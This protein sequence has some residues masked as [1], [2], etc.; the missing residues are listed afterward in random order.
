M[1]RATRMAAS[2]AWPAGE[3]VTSVVLDYDARHRRRI[4]LA[5]EDASTVL[6]DLEKATV[7]RDGDGLALEGGG[8]VAVRAAPED[9]AEV[10]CNNAHALHR[11]AWHLGNR[12]CPAAIEADRILIRRD[13]VIE[14]ML[15]GIGAKVTPV[16]APFDPERGAYDDENQVHGHH[17]D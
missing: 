1:Q 11:I 5:C 4:R 15:Q 6:L 3:A 12:H 7:L 14:E 8:W 16:L 9:L 17:H 10:T 2:G 13:H